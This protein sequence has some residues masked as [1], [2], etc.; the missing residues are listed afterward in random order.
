VPEA[1]DDPPQQRLADGDRQAAAA[2]DDAITGT[3]GWRI[4]ELGGGIDFQPKWDY[5]KIRR[6]RS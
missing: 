3:R 4:L 1:I 2:C 6:G 5:K